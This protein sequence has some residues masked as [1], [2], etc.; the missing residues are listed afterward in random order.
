MNKK[1]NPYS[2]IKPGSLATPGTDHEKALKKMG[3][4]KDDDNSWLPN[5]QAVT[6][7]I[8]DCLTMAKSFSGDYIYN[9][10]SGSYEELSMVN[11]RSIYRCIMDQLSFAG[12]SFWDI[13]LNKQIEYWATSWPFLL[14]DKFNSKNY[15]V[16]DNCS[17]DLTNFKVVEH[18]ADQYST[19]HINYNYDANACCPLFEKFI[20]EVTCNRDDLIVLIQEVLGYLLASHS[21]A[22]KA[23]IIIGS[24]RNGKSVMASVIKALIGSENISS[25][26]LKVLGK[27]FGCEDLINKQ[28]NL[29][30]ESDRNELVG[31]SVWKA[32]V[33][34]DSVSINPKGRKRYTDTLDIKIVSFL[35]FFPSFGELDKSILRRLLVIPFD[36]NIPPDEIDP[37]LIDKLV[38]EKQGIMNWAIEG[39][40]RLSNNN[41]QFSY[42]KASDDLLNRLIIESDPLAQYIA[43]YVE[44]NPEKKPVK[45]Q[46]F[47][48]SFNSFALK[49]GYETINRTFNRDFTDKLLSLGYIFD[50]VN[51]HGVQYIK[52]LRIKQQDNLCQIIKEA[53]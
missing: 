12:F 10:D 8:F 23:F 6:D 27:E 31:T 11:M 49:N 32:I 3:F 9:F 42:S 26:P 29:T 46:D 18:C 39:L 43:E 28:V 7:Y 14:L 40:K 36:A 16:F 41:W 15:L 47:H 17:Y 44:L 13:K 53:I 1:F 19:R 2:Y 24:G 21:K 30:T 48:K 37:H 4:F 25:T 38:L 51:I 5:M 50:K 20:R 34:N 22:E 52:G 45:Y 33:S 35:N